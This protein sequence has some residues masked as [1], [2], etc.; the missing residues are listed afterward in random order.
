MNRKYKYIVLG[1]LLSCAFVNAQDKKI[2]KATTDFNTYAYSD[3][4]DSY[5]SLVKKGHTSEEVFKNLGNA[6]YQNADYEAAVDWF[7]QLFELEDAEI[8]AE[9]LYKYAQTL[10]SLGEYGKSD[11]WMQ[12][13]EAAKANDNRA[14][15]FANNL[16]YLN[17]IEEN[18][19]RY[20]IK[21]LSINTEASD[22][23]PS[24]YGKEL[25]F[26]SAR[27][28]GRIA[29][30]IHEW[31]NKPFL[32]LYRTIPFENGEFSTT[33]KLSKSLN[34]KTHESSTAFT[35]DGSTVYFT[36]NNSENGRFARDENG[37]SR[38]K[39]YKADLQDGEWSD[40]IELPFNDDSYS[41]AHP[42]LSSDEKQLYFASDMPGTIGQSDIFVV[43]IQENGSFG[44]PKNLGNKINTEGRETFPFVTESNKLYFASDGHPGLGGLDIFVTLLNEMEYRPLKNIG[45]PINSA[46]DDFSFIGDEGTKK[47]F[48]AS[49]REGGF[50]SD[51]IYSFTQTKE[52]DLSCH[53]IVEGIINDKDNERPISG[54]NIVIIDSKG[55]ALS[56]T[57]SEP[58]G[59][60]FIEVN[61]GDGPYKIIASKTEYGQIEIMFSVQNTND[62][63]GIEITLERTV[64]QAKVGTDLVKFLELSPVYFNLDKSNIRPDAETTLKKLID[65]M[66][67][68]PDLKVEVRSHT[69][70]KAGSLYN[71]NLSEI[72]AKATVAYVVAN[73]IYKN[74]ITGQGFGETKLINDCTSREKCDDSEHQRNR[75][76]EV[77]VIE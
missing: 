60:F 21:N 74:R 29:R 5:E 26:S 16:N 47:G 69:D 42:T 51:D 27:D 38:L 49:N 8:E 50:G 35:K 58:N 67:Q 7:A 56:T 66:R 59:T 10:K 54:A 62:T 65:Y 4:I 77:I 20:K 33:E 39:I 52:I 25:V 61:C 23:A 53:T 55:Q 32:N 24:F 40:I 46:Q 72:R 68:F 28:K 41:V 44:T 19:G 30:N 75:R 45:K 37:L 18:S 76:S 3:A 13:F 9:Y 34:R 57:V 63:S 1:S 36:R 48:F 6:H 70:A 71:Q 64:K 43:D 17:E 15:K 14:I 31:N 12:K 73:G 2:K 11:Q 22:F